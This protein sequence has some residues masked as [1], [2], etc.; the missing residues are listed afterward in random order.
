MALVYRT[1]YRLGRGTVAH[2]H[3]GAVALLAIGFD[4]LLTVVSTLLGLVLR[5]VFWLV[6]GVLALAIFLI[7]LPFRVVAGLLT[8][9]RDAVVF[10]VML[11]FRLVAWILQTIGRVLMAAAAVL[12]LGLV[13]P[14]RRPQ[15][16]P[17]MLPAK[18]R[19]SG[20]DEL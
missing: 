19:W 4:L 13:G 10:V 9:I 6:R 17:L 2:T 16:V 11:P 14:R 5:P 15:P 18:P 7:A 12:T 1:E 20:L 8:L 3:T